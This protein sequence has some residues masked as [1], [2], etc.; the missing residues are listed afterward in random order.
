MRN[1]IKRSLADH[2]GISTESIDDDIVVGSDIVRDEDGVSI[3]PLVPATN[4]PIVEAH[5]TQMTA[6]MVDIENDS[7]VIDDANADIETLESIQTLLHDSCT[8]GIV[9]N[10]SYDMFNIAMNHVYRKHGIAAAKVF[11]SMESFESDRID[12]ITVSMERI[13]DTLNVVKENVVEFIK[14]LWFKI[15]QF[16]GDIVNGHVM[17]K[18]RISYILNNASNLKDVDVNDVTV[19]RTIK[20]FAANKLHVGGK[21]PDRRTIAVTFAD[22]VVHTIA[23]SK[24]LGTVYAIYNSPEYA[25]LKESMKPKLASAFKELTTLSSRP[26]FQD[27]KFVRNEAKSNYFSVKMEKTAPPKRDA[28]STGQ[29]VQPLLPKQIVEIC[30]ALLKSD[31]ALGTINAVFRTSNFQKSIIDN[32]QTV[33]EEHNKDMVDMARNSIKDTLMIHGKIINYYYSINKAML[34]YCTQS[35]QVFK[36]VEKADGK[37]D[38]PKEEPVAE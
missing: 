20:L 9:S 4:M 13:K 12:A 29:Q 22:T 17:M 5:E 27:V 33:N 10:E 23:V 26:V 7:D 8:N 1:N 14:K 35:L 28:D 34:D 31:E 24:I 21:L 16:V 3:S 36:A 15:K 30:K 18:Q 6:D 19:D 38:K 25:H 32:M 11:P 2:F 37:Q